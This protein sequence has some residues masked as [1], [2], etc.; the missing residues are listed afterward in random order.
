MLL[1]AAVLVL[2]GAVA[3]I[4]NRT[5]ARNAQR[6][7]DWTQAVGTVVRFAAGRVAYRY[8]PSRGAV[9]NGEALARL[10]ANYRE[11]GKVLVYVNPANPAESLIDFPPRPSTIPSVVGGIALLAGLVLAVGAWSM[12]RAPAGGGGRKTV[13]GKSAGE[14]TTRRRQ[15]PLARLQPPPPVKWKRED[16]KSPSPTPPPPS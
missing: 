8:E 15:P 3:I 10:G 6:S 14:T 12:E 9:Q 2:A 16:E 7:V 1:T 5:A 11:G 4:A 13:A